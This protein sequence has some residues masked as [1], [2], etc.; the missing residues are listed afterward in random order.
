MVVEIKWN[1]ILALPSLVPN[2]T[3]LLL[4]ETPYQSSGQARIK[5]MKDTSGGKNFVI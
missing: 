5:A 4:G 1:V 2:R 3:G